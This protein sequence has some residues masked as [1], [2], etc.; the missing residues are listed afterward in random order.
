LSE[1]RGCFK[2]GCLGCLGAAALVLFVIV[3][4][5]VLGLLTGGREER[6]EP[7]DRTHRIRTSDSPGITGAEPSG[8]HS[9]A[10]I[11]REIDVAEPGRIVLDLNR[12]SFEIRPGPPGE[13]IRL[14]G[15]YDAGHFDL[16]ER[17][18]PYGETG[19]TYRVSFDQRGLGIQPF[20]QHERSENL[21]RLIVPRDA[22]IV[23]EGRVGIG[24]SELELGGLWLLDVDLEMGI[25]EHTVSFGEPLPIPM[26]RLRLDTSI[27][28]LVVDGI[29]N[30][31]PREVRVKH[32][33]G[34]VGVDLRGL[35][36]RDAEIFVLCGIGECN[37]QVPRDVGLKVDRASVTL[38]DASRPHEWPAPEAGRPT[39]KL[40]VS[41]NIGEVLVH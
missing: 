9:Q 4:L 21:V 28:E 34:E 19:W 3:V 33:I 6:I 15:R 24:E 29:G 40:S 36:R 26:G 10:P 13:A 35:W 41:G 8:E 16:T 7:I 5:V 18:E 31:S 32:S 23:L 30:A 27:G 20:V 38:G 14:E 1:K 2:T 11:V 37:V 17:Y 12:G 25:G 22:P 39:L